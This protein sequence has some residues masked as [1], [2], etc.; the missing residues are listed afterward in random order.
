MGCVDM[1]HQIVYYI[2][3]KTIVVVLHIQCV[4]TGTFVSFIIEQVFP[5][6]Y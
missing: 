5:E 6:L 2:V 1:S 3:V 4:Y